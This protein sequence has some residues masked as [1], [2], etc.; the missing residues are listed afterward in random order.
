MA[1][2]AI[3]FVASLCGSI[4]GTLIG[5]SSLITIPTLILLGLLAHTAIGTDR[6][7]VT[8]RGIAGWYQ[9]HKKGMI[10]YRVALSVGIPVLLGAILGGQPCPQN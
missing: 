3:A 8:G 5:G 7:G 1:S 4:Y 9:F 2:L 10:N 6:V